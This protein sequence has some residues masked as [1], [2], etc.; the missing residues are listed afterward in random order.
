MSKLIKHRSP[1][2]KTEMNISDHA[3]IVV[4]QTKKKNLIRYVRRIKF[5]AQADCL[6]VEFS[7]EDKKKIYLKAIDF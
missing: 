3:V 7:K 6:F 1:P 5:E 2:E 4:S